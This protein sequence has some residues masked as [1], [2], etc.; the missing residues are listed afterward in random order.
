MIVM[1]GLERPDLVEVAMPL[2]A[3]DSGGPIFDLR[4]GRVVALVD[5]GPGQMADVGLGIDALV[6]R[7]LI[8]EWAAAPQPIH[9]SSC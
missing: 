4:D 2:G 8:G 9:G 3:G 5:A 1:N 6:A 7:G